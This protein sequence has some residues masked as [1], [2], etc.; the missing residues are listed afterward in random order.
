MSWSHELRRCGTLVCAYWC[1]CGNAW[2][3]LCTCTG[4]T[5]DVVE[6]PAMYMWHVRV[7]I[8]VR[9]TKAISM[10]TRRCLCVQGDMYVYTATCMETRAISMYTR[11]CVRI[12]GD[13][14]RRYLCVQGDMYVCTVIC[15]YTRR[16]LCVRGDLYVY[17][18]ILQ[19]DIYVYKVICMYI[20]RCLCIQGETCMYSRRYVCIQGDIDV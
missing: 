9:N 18:P 12:Q 20:R 19:G 10:Y 13:I 3:Y 4:D 7:W 14:T 1:A 16:Y 5:D 2:R 17:K 15:M 11:R 8:L 6:S